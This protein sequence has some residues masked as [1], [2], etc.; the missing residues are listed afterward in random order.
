M[1]ATAP[2][3]WLRVGQLNVRSI[4][5]NRDLV[6]K[7]VSDETLH[8]LCLQETWLAPGEDLFYPGFVF[9]RRDRNS[10][11]GG[12]AIGVRGD[13]LST[14]VRL[15]SGLLGAEVVA[16][17]VVKDGVAVF[18]VSVY[19]GGQVLDRASWE[20]FVAG[21]PVP[22]I[23]CGDF[24]GHANL[25]DEMGCNR[26]GKVLASYFDEAPDMWLI[27]PRGSTMVFSNRKS[28]PDLTITSVT[29]RDKVT[30]D[31]GP[32]VNSDHY[33]AI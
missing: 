14:T 26:N 7:M 9:Y 23:I 13:V 19:V 5:A 15:R 21:I 3:K 32:N 22:F 10:S 25:W 12:V 18:M 29:F 20:R 28:V 24:N 31:L 11:G 6:R 2:D 4:R 30:W 27:S 17:R 33:P 8:V 1:A 16:A